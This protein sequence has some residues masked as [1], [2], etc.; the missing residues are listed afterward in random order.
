MIADGHALPMNVRR[1]PRAAV[2]AAAVLGAFAL[3]LQLVL[4]VQLVRAQGGSTLAAVWVYFDYFTVLTNLLLAVT[5]AVAAKKS[6][7]RFGGWLRQ[8]A[9][10]TAIAASILIVG[11]VYNLL[12]RGIWQP[13]GWQRLADELL[14]VV[15]PLIGV[16]FWW[17]E[18]RGDHV[19]PKPLLAWQLYP[20]GYL[21]YALIRGAVDGHYPYPFLDVALLGYPLVLI[22]AAGVALVF[23]L[24]GGVMLAI[25]RWRIRR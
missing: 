12:L 11:I 23:V 17:L 5:L 18:T 20:L 10:L 25:A 4:T 6:R 22:N 3:L 13:T 7:G 1:L 15:M 14:H 9:S 8:P 16:V 2:A 21:A 19:R 24:V